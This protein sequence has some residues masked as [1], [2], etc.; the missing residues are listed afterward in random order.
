M[1]LAIQDYFDVWTCF[2]LI[3]TNTVTGQKSIASMQ[4]GSKNLRPKTKK[5]FIVAPLYTSIQKSLR[6]T[7]I[8][9]KT[10]I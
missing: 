10:M 3:P 4:F 9:E 5:F 6:Q 8:I 1:H 7:S 2:Y